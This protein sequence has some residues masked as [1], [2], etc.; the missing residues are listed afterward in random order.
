MYQAKSGVKNF[1]LYW[2]GGVSL[3]KKFPYLD[4]DLGPPP[5]PDLDLGPPHPELDL[6]P[7][8]PRLGTPPTRTWTWDPPYPDL[9][10]GP[11]PP[12][13][14]LTNKLKTV[15]SPILRMRAVIIKK[16]Y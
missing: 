15:P 5:H 3:D 12:R 10:L 4:L 2:G 11:P 6:G 1:P 9:D 8:L 13:C 7:P 16:I 14:E